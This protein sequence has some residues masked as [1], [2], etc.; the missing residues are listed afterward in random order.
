M[1]QI[2]ILSEIFGDPFGGQRRAQIFG[3]LT[4]FD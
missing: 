3:I 2:W 1:V 4:V